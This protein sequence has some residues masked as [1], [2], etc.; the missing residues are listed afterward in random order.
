MN[1]IKA[2]TFD[3]RVRQDVLDLTICGLG[4]QRLVCG[5]CVSD[6][7]PLLDHRY[8]TYQTDKPPPLHT[9]ILEIL[10]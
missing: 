1:K 6:E 8:I 5:W 10:A 4:L 2:P 7:P 3:I 9:S